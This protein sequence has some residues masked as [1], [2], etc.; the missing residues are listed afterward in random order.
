[1]KHAAKVCKE[2]QQLK[3]IRQ[4]YRNKQ[5]ADGHMGKCKQ[6]HKNAVYANRELKRDIYEARRREWLAVPENREKH[7]ASIRA[8]RKTERG[9]QV[10]EECR[11]I[12]RALNPER[13]AEIQRTCWQNANAKRK[14]RRALARAA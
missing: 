10:M 7:Y 14:Q 6:C 3:S 2:C 9:K 1:M 5:N 8:W 11:K 12:W 4:F 13:Y